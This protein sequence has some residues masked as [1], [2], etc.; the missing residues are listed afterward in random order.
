MYVGLALLL[1]VTFA[2]LVITNHQ[3]QQQE[4]LIMAIPN[5]SGHLLSVHA[6]EAI[7]DR[8]ALTSYGQEI[9]RTTISRIMLTYE[10]RQSRSINALQ[11]RHEV[12]LIGTNHSLP[13]V[14][15]YSIISGSFFSQD[16][17]IH[18]HRVAVLNKSA[19]FELFGNIYAAGN[20]LSIDNMPYRV[21][22]VIDDGD[23]DNFNIY[24]PI[25]LMGNSVGAIAA[26]FSVNQDLSEEYILTVWQLL[27]VTSDRYS[28]IN[29]DI[30][31]T[32]AQ[33]RLVL[34]IFLMLLGLLS[35][36][37]FKITKAVKK[38]WHAFCTL[39]REM[40][41]TDLLK[42]KSFKRL[43]MLAASLTTI[44]TAVAVI[45][46]NAFSRILIAYDARDMLT[47]IR[48]EVFSIQIA[49]MARW[50]NMSGL[51]FWGFSAVFLIVCLR[52]FVVR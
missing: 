44:V 48:S 39:K 15:N 31:G 45:C 3:V 43:A 46:L 34:A 8:V 30:L 6:V 32:I 18:G 25:T 20:E 40:Y 7:N 2:G 5:T 12:T 52:Y 13:H 35:W 24:V 37:I 9:E 23:A 47:D 11:S 27:G 38:E 26:N 41:M 22:G 1:A 16:A 50:Y 10:I 51:F 36:G 19:A 29:F 42:G 17:L 4:R 49:E 33:D 14:L 28:F 21:A